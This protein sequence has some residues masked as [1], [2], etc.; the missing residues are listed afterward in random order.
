MVEDEASWKALLSLSEHYRPAEH[1]VGPEQR[2]CLRSGG[3]ICEGGPIK[4]AAESR[5]QEPLVPWDA[6]S[7][8]A[9]ARARARK[10]R[11]KAKGRAKLAKLQSWRRCLP[12]LNES[13]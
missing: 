11:P 13:Q 5:S 8:E 4:A 10:V 1:H 9:E 12:K 2:P 3:T 7:H 6:H